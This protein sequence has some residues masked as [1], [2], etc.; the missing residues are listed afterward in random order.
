VRAF[1]KDRSVYVDPDDGEAF[2]VDGAG[3]IGVETDDEMI[4]WY[5]YRDGFVEVETT[6]PTPEQAALLALV[7]Y[8]ITGEPGRS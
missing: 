1:L 7:S 6:A 4:R 3:R 2:F 8:G 5:A